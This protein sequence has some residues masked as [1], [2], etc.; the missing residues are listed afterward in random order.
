MRSLQLHSSS[1]RPAGL[2]A[3]TATPAKTLTTGKPKNANHQNAPC[4]APAPTT[5]CHPAAQ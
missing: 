4:G 2:M 5:W 1:H 3:A